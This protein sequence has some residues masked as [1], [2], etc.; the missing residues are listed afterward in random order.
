[1]RCRRVRAATLSRNSP[2]IGPLLA[3]CGRSALLSWMPNTPAPWVAV[4]TTPSSTPLNCTMASPLPST[5]RV[6]APAMPTCTV[7]SPATARPRLVSPLSAVSSSSGAKGGATCSTGTR[8]ALIATGARLPEAFKPIARL[9]PIATAPAMLP[10]AFRPTPRVPAACTP[11]TAGK[12]SQLHTSMEPL[13]SQAL[14]ACRFT[15]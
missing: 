1:M 14:T 6:R 7:A 11:T 10:E 3:M 12:A 15:Y 5:Q 4:T 13:T 2:L 8:L 9:P